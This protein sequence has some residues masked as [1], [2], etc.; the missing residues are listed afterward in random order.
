[1]EL[2]RGIIVCG[3]DVLEGKIGQAL[4]DT[5]CLSHAVT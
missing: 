4:K 2:G 3:T 1:M 5:L